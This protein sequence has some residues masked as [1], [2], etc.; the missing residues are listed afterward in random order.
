MRP[1][2][3]NRAAPVQAAAK[4]RNDAGDKKVYFVD[5]A[6]W[7]TREDTNDGVHPTKEGHRKI[8]DKLAP[9]LERV[10]KGQSPQ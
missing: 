2:S 3:G 5:T 8:A 6:G 7:V 1:F 4:A 9:M 10:L